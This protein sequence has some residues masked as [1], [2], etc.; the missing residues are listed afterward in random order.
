MALVALRHVGSA[1]TRDGALC[2]QMDSYPLSCQ[3]VLDA[4]LLIVDGTPEQ[5]EN[6]EAE[7]GTAVF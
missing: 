6:K 7:T 2:W 5:K 4:P 3:G 1:Q